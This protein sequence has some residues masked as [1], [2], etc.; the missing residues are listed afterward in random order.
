MRAWIRVGLLASAA[1][2]AVSGTSGALAAETLQQALVKTYE[3]NPQLLAQRASLRAT[4]ENVAQ[5]L[6]LW[7]PNVSVTGTQSDNHTRS[8]IKAVV[9]PTKTNSEPWSARLTASQT[10]FAGGRIL[11]QRMQAGAEVRAARATL[12][13]TEQDIFLATVSAY[14][15]VVRDLEIVRLNEKSVELLK[16][17]REAAQERFKV[18]EITRTDVA[19]AEARLAQTEAGLVAAQA[20][21]KASSLAYESLVGNTP[22]GL[23]VEP[24]LPP[25]PQSEDATRTLAE[26]KSPTYIAAIENQTASEHGVNR[27]V[28]SLLPTVS[29][30]A[31]Y[32]Y[33]NAGDISPSTRTESTTVSG[34]L[35]VPL[36]QGGAEW[37]SIRQTEEFL[38]QAKMNREQARRSALEDAS[39]AWEAYRSAKA[40]RE[41]NEQQLKAQEIA[42]EGVQQEAEVGTR[43]TI[44]V[45]DAQRELLNSQVAVARSRRDEIVA[46]HQL[47]AAIGELTAQGLNLPVKI[48][49]PIENYNDNSGKWIGPS[50][51]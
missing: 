36:Y 34:V 2:F 3:T 12:H 1:V 17:Q 28:G 46:A 37:S 6:S 13:A 38:N 26:Q 39:N 18:G 15:N 30:Q 24:P 29:V 35:T 43:T 9:L 19:Q 5:A 10:L 22:E 47:M 20:S 8:E 41:S 48:Y 42:F 11:A 25:L 31:T 40:Q 51:Y 50:G 21:L 14:M 23:E 32:D 33:G 7:R 45:L 27:A 16:K 44:D 49:D 4:D